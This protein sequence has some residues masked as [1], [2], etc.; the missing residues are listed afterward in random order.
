MP[1][2]VA[3]N[4]DGTFTAQY[5]PQGPG[6]YAVAIKYANQEIPKSPIPVRVIPSVDVS[7]IKVDGLADSEYLDCRCIF[8]EIYNIM[9]DLWLVK[10]WRYYRIHNSIWWLIYH[11]L[12]VQGNR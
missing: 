4:G 1:C 12:L 8:C 5:Q 9:F 10:I 3:D 2:K 7:K 6:E 11:C